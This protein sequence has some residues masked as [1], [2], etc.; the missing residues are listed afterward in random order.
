MLML[1]NAML[2]LLMSL[3]SVA[4]RRLSPSSSHVL[5]LLFFSFSCDMP[6]F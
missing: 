4:F 1:T 3:F 5:R 6:M 2:P